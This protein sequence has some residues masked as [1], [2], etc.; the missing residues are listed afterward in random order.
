MTESRWSPLID[1]GA[2]AALH[3]AATVWSRAQPS[4]VGAS[5]VAEWLVLAIDGALFAAVIL[6]TVIVWRQSQP[7][8][9]PGLGAGDLDIVELAAVRGG[10]LLAT[11]TA[12]TALRGHA[13]EQPGNGLIIARGRLRAGAGELERELFE[14]ARTA[15]QVPTKDHV[16]RMASSETAEEIVALAVGAGLRLHWVP[17][18]RLTALWRCAAATMFVG[19][20]LVVSGPVARGDGAWLAAS[21]CLTVLATIL[22]YW[23]AGHRE[24]PTA[25]GYSRSPTSISAAEST[26]T[27]STTTPAHTRS[28]QASCG[29]SRSCT[30]AST[31]PGSCSSTDGS[32]VGA[33]AAGRP[34]G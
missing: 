12:A 3:G 19:R 5:H 11:V 23:I 15:P 10:A 25:A 16:A 34:R 28:C 17:T 20:G 33:S 21:G 8:V 2:L 26:A 6:T 32:R 18:T 14:L 31:R 13:D 1:A 7:A 4:N 22:T 30:H 27:A 24:G 29:S 9:E